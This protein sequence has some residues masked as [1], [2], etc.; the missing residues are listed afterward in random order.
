M[1]EISLGIMVI[2]SDVSSARSDEERP[3]GD[4]GT[5]WGLPFIWAGVGIEFVVVRGNPVIRT[6]MRLSIE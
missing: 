1:G 6:S 5:D 2:P 4:W 3:N